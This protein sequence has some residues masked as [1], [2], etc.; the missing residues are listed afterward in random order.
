MIWDA[1]LKRPIQSRFP[2]AFHSTSYQ[3]FWFDCSSIC[4]VHGLYLC[5]QRG[6]P[7]TV[8][9]SLCHPAS[10]ADTAWPGLLFQ[11]SPSSLPFLF[12]CIS[13]S[14]CCVTGTLSETFKKYMTH[15]KEWDSVSGSRLQP[16]NSSFKEI[17]YH[18][19]CDLN[20]SRFTSVTADK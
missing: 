18:P 15:E 8:I 7:S 2:G 1:D 4:S 9:P 6:F 3:G 13:C 11:P 5:L 16:S 20:L 14:F 17:Y 10:G 19:H 12:H